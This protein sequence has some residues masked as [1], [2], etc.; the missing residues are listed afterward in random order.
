MYSIKEVAEK[1]GLNKATIYLKIARGE[2]EHYVIGNK[3]I[4]IS[5]EQ[6]QEFLEKRKN[7]A[8]KIKD[9]I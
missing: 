9:W 4:R 2:L 6:L 7:K 1:L 8:V 5:E 3:T